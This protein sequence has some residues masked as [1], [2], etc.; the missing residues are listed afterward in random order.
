MHEPDE[1]GEYNRGG[2]NKSESASLGFSDII[3]TG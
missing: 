1:H 2:E 3:H